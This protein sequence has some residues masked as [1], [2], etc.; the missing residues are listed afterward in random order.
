MIRLPVGEKGLIINPAVSACI[1]AMPE[2][3]KLLWHIPQLR[4]R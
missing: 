4:A 1:S 2:Q 3:A